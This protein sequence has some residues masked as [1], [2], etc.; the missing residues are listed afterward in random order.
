VDLYSEK[1]FLRAAK[2]RELPT[3]K[4]FQHFSTFLFVEDKYLRAYCVHILILLTP[5]CNTEA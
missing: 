5:I 1:I 3:A 4:W 2:I